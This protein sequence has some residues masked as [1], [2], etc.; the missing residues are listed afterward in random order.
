MTRR[1]SSPGVHLGHDVR[2][3]RGLDGG[4]L[5]GDVDLRSFEAGERVFDDFD[6]GFG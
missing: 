1:G 2:P 6:G 3:P 5:G 4:E